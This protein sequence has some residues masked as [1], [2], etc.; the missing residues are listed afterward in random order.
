MQTRRRTESLEA[1]SISMAVSNLPLER[2][3]AL[4]RTI[5]EEANEMPAQVLSEGILASYEPISAEG[6]D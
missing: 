5:K 6:A 2:W 4:A 3:K 1:C